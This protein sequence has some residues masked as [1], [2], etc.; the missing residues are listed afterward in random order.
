MV[1]YA[2]A[3]LR[4]LHTASSAVSVQV[5]SVTAACIL[6]PQG[7]KTRYW[8]HAPATTPCRHQLETAAALPVLPMPGLTQRAASNRL[9]TNGALVFWARGRAQRERR[10]YRVV[11]WRTLLRGWGVSR[12]QIVAARCA[13][14]AGSSVQMRHAALW[15]YQASTNCWRYF[16]RGRERVLWG[17]RR[18]PQHPVWRAHPP[19]RSCRSLGDQVRGRCS[20]CAFS[21]STCTPSTACGRVSAGFAQNWLTWRCA[22]RSFTTLRTAHARQGGHQLARTD[23]N[24]RLWRSAALAEYHSFQRWPILNPAAWRRIRGNI[25]RRASDSAGNGG[26]STA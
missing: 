24:A 7:A 11:R 12:A 19:Q 10:S 17:A 6:P 25:W 1:S 3:G 8:R 2:A 22:R 21:F 18:S 14:F 15:H 26:C 4:G 13:H 16:Y 5:D 23:T 20:L 9:R